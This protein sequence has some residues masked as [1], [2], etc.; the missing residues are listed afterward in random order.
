MFIK[1]PLMQVVH[2]LHI[3]VHRRADGLQRMSEGGVEKRRRSKG[4]DP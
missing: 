2:R 3:N 4:L 1:G